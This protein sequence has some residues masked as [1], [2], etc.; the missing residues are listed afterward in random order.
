M[1]T[2]PADLNVQNIPDV[3]TL[4][5]SSSSLSPGGSHAVD[6]INNVEL[7]KY[8]LD[9]ASKLFDTTILDPRGQNFLT[10]VNKNIV[11]RPVVELNRNQTQD[12]SNKLPVCFLSC[13]EST[14]QVCVLSRKIGCKC[15]TSWVCDNKCKDIIIPDFPNIRKGSGSTKFCFNSVNN[16]FLTYHLKVNPYGFYPDMA[17]KIMRRI[18]QKKCVL[19]ERHT[20]ISCSLC[21]KNFCLIRDRQC[22]Y[23]EAHIIF[24]S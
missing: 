3:V 23:H 12:K 19:C 6:S 16:C 22:F 15:R 13:K 18:P 1:I 17:K 9:L 5:S 7:K 24:H 20:T 11:N 4:S 10:N 21:Q 14:S 2:I 8:F